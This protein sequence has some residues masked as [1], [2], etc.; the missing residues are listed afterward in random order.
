MNYTDLEKISGCTTAERYKTIIMEIL[1]LFK[2]TT[3]EAPSIDEVTPSVDAVTPHY[4]LDVKEKEL[5]YETGSYYYDIG[6]KFKFIPSDTY[7]PEENIKHEKLAH[8]F[9]PFSS[10]DDTKFEGVIVYK[11]DLTK[12]LV[13]FLLMDYG[14]LETKIQHT[15][16]VSPQSYKSNVMES[17]AL[18]WD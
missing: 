13:E 18:L 14:E 3:L 8:P 9:A 15:L 2:A 1:A 7:E 6:Y 5:K 12:M 11:N 17:L 4:T 16:K 10:D